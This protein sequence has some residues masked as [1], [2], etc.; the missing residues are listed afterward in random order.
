[1]V[2]GGDWAVGVGGVTPVCETLDNWN[3]LHRLKFVA[4][5]FHS[6]YQIGKANCSKSI[7]VCLCGF[8]GILQRRSV[9]LHGTEKSFRL[10]FDKS[11]Q[12]DV[13]M[14]RPDLM[15]SKNRVREIGKVVC[16]NV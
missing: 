1:M 14:N 12:K 7:D 16:D 4:M 15:V 13:R 10:L 6:E 8:W 5:C 2:V 3:L 11:A 9:S